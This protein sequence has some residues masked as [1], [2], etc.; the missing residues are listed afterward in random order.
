MDSTS[1]VARIIH[2]CMVGPTLRVCMKLRK[3]LEGV[4]GVHPSRPARGQRSLI[5]VWG[6]ASGANVCL[7][8]KLQKHCELFSVPCI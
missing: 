4:G 5:G 7:M 3:P 8:Y 2:V 1:G 6:R